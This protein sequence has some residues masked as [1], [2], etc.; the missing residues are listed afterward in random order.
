MTRILVIEDEPII[1]AALTRLLSRHGYDVLE[2]GSVESA[3]E[4][5]ML[6]DADLIIADL[7]LPGAPGTAVIDLAEGTPVLMMTSY[8]R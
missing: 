1:R 8:A 7:R 2:A 5:T 3:V 6:P 4:Q